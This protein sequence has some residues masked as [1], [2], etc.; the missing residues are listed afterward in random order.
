MQSSRSVDQG[1]CNLLYTARARAGGGE[2]G[3]RLRRGGAAAAAC[4]LACFWSN[5]V[6]GIERLDLQMDGRE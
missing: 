2:E 6:V 5:G 1:D 3:L 4:L